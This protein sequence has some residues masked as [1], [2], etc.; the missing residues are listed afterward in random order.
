MVLVIM[1]CVEELY[2]PRF[3][4]AWPTANI[5]VMSGASAGKTLT[6]IQVAALKKK[7]QALSEEEQHKLQMKL[8]TAITNKPTSVML[9]L[10]CGLMIIHPTQTRERISKAINVANLNPVIADFK[11]GVLQV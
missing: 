2:D 8:L 6:Q 11:T 5:A 1:R 7:G 3:M 10:D 4:Y 9:P